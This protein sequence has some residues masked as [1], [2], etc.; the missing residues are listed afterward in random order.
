MNGQDLTIAVLI[1]TVLGFVIPPIVSFLR[2]VHT[3]P[4]Y[5][6]YVYTA[7]VFGGAFLALWLQKAILVHPPTDTRGNVIYWAGDFVLV[8]NQA[9]VLYDQFWKTI[10]LPATDY[11]EQ[12]GPRPGDPPEPAPAQPAPA[13]PPAIPPA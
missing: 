4:Q 7:I 12:N 9:K 1:T 13:V 5:I 10:A 3:P 6:G 2:G 11:L 8:Y